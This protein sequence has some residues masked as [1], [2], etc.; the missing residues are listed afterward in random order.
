MVKAKI[1]SEVS[2]KWNVKKSL[3]S[4]KWLWKCSPEYKACQAA[5][6]DLHWEPIGPMR[7]FSLYLFG[8]NQDVILKE[9]FDGL[10]LTA[11]KTD[12]W[13]TDYKNNQTNKAI[14]GAKSSKLKKYVLSSGITHCL[15]LF[16]KWFDWQ[17]IDCIQW[18]FNSLLLNCRTIVKKHCVKIIASWP[19]LN[20]IHN[21]SMYRAPKSNQATV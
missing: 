6:H 12:N 13:K 20:V 19:I 10:M 16:K 15:S 17:M 18:I 7:S 2:G 3:I 14:Y 8:S 1:L 11:H 9:T 5:Y 21:D 4:D